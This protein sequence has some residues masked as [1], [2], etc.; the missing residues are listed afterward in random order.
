MR[1]HSVLISPTLLLSVIA[2]SL[3]VLPLG[4]LT[5]IT[6]TQENAGGGVVVDWDVVAQIREEGLQRSQIANTLSYMTDVLGARLTNSIA[7]DNAQHWAV[8]EMK[9]IGLTGT[10]REPFM[11]YGVSWDNEYVS[12]HLLEPDYQPMVGYPI[13]HTPG[14]N[15]KQELPAVIADVRTRQ[16]LETLEG[17]IRGVAVLSTPP[18]II[19]LSRFETG[20]PKRSAQ[21]MRELAEA[22][23]PPPPGPDPYFSRLYPDPPQ[24]PDVLTAAERLAF[25]VKE[26]VAVVLES[27]SGWPGAVRGF[28]RPGAKI[29]LWS[30]DATMSSV[31][32]VAVTPEHYNRMYRILRRG[33]PV[34][35]EVE[36]RNS[37]GTS[38][39][40]ASNVLG[41]IPGTDLAQEVVMMGAHF[42][43]WHASPNASDNTSGVAVVLEAARILKAIGAEP[44]R[45]IRVA[46]WSGEEQG[47]YG[48]RAYVRE[49]FG[50]PNDT[51]IGTTPEYETFSAYFNQDYGPGQYRGIWL[52]ENE[53]VRQIFKAWMEPFHDMG[54]T[55]ISLQGVGST[56]HVPF[57]NIGLP[58]FQFLQ[59][60][61]GGTGGHT[62]LDFFDTVPIEDL[63]KNAV[64]MAS[65][66]Y[67]A[68][69]ADE[70]IPRKHTTPHN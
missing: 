18:A 40:Q 30:R 38:V 21:E 19:D 51:N 69:M 35:L 26:G 23:V 45:T 14:T 63:M 20:T 10:N 54:M 32:I 24:N 3:S 5:Q 13:A 28:A 25:Y 6:S 11:E 27:S 34:S 39:E 46:L 2:T 53:H 57:D 55:T 41:E 56:D 52:Q 44:R 49:H 17:K 7:M 64:I 67:H 68:A 43:T 12:I 66:A 60:R 16:D 22:V 50:N 9:R 58:A 42:D 65:F 29:D 33:I 61:V 4:A 37:H 59:A 36:V 48:S 62:N 15:G 47:L 1:S 8:E 31:P 70:R